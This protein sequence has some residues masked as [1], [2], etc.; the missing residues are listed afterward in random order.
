MAAFIRTKIVSRNFVPRQLLA[1]WGFP[2]LYFGL[3]ANEIEDNYTT[4]TCQ[5]VNSLRQQR[6]SVVS[7]LLLN[8]EW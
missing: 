4:Q 3:L 1:T 5:A 7:A 8:H 6:Q 2:A